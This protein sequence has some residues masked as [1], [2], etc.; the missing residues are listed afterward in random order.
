MPKQPTVGPT[1][2]TVPLISYNFFFSD[3]DDCWAVEDLISQPDQGALR[4]RATHRR[5]LPLALRPRVPFPQP[6]PSLFPPK[7]APE[8]EQS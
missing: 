1:V 7:P 6:N 2:S 5:R 3:S 4:P 8:F